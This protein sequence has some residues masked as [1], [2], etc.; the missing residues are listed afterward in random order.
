MT[1]AQGGKYIYTDHRSCDPV[2]TEPTSE[3]CHRLK[4]NHSVIHGLEPEDFCRP[5][6]SCTISR[7]NTPFPRSILCNSL[8][9]WTSTGA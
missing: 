2:E 6:A 1:M 5:E 8:I 3:A 7:Q 4:R 9:C